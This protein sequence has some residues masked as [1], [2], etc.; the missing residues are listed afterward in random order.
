MLDVFK[1]YKQLQKEDVIF[2]FKG[3]VSSDL[4]QSVLDI[5][6]I[7][8]EFAEKSSKTKKKVFNVLVEMLQNLNHHI[9]SVKSEQKLIDEGKNAVFQICV[10]EESYVINTGNFMPNQNVESLENWL[11]YINSTTEEELRALYKEKLNDKFTPK[12]GGGL[13][14]IDIARKSGQKLVYCFDKIDEYHSFFSFQIN[15]PKEN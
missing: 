10:N 8:L 6:E 1:R 15:I 3:E 5:M 9:E 4:V 2:F 14:F 12:G 7:R 11:K 13:G